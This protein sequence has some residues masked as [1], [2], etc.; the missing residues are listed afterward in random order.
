MARPVLVLLIAAVCA[1]WLLGCASQPQSEAP[2]D[3]SSRP[4]EDIPLSSF[5]TFGGITLGEPVGV[6]RDFDG[7]ILIADRA[8]GQVVHLLLASGQAVEFDQP[9]LGVGFSPSDLKSSGFFVYA[10]DPIER[11]LVRFYKTGSYLGVLVDMRERFPGRRV[12]PVGLDVDGSGRIAMT[13]TKNHEVIIFNTYLDVEL[14]F[15]SYGKYAGQ[16]D[17]PEGIFFA[18]GGQLLVADSGNRRVQLFDPD[19]AFVGMVPREGDPNPLKRPRRAVMDKSGWIYVADPAAAG[20]FV[21]DDMGSLVRT[22][23]PRGAGS[24]RPTDVTVAPDG[25]IYVTDEAMSSLYT[26]R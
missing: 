16:L 1:Q 2:S 12:T 10:V 20:V 26:F 23:S 3:L 22:I 5:R 13:D 9:P 7:N 24:F 6:A 19:G 14:Q 18:L 8:P 15:G 21:F 17:S 11:V 4:G 25:T